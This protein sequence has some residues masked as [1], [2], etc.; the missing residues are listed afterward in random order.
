[1]KLKLCIPKS[2]LLA[3]LLHVFLSF[4]SFSQ[5]PVV[6]QPWM[7]VEGTYNG[8]RLG[9]NV[10]FAGKIDD[11]T[12]ITASD[13]NGIKMYHIKSPNDT[14]PRFFFSGYN[15]SLG[16]F[17][18]DGIQ[19]LLVNGK[20]TKIYLG[21][22]V[23]VF[24]T[25][26]FFTK[27]ME[28]NGYA[29][30]RR[31]AVG[32]INEDLFDD[33]IITDAGYPNGNNVGRVYIFFGGMQ[34][35]TIPSYI[36]NG[37]YNRSGFGWN[38]ATGDLN[39]DGIDDIIVRGYD[40]NNPVSNQR[41][42]YIKVFLGGNTID[43]TTWKYIKGIL[44]SSFGLSC[45]DVNGDGVKDL[46]WTNYSI[47]DSMNSVYIHFSQN[48]NIDTLPSLVLPNSWAQNVT[49]AGDMNGDG[50]DDILISSNGSD[51]GGNSYIFIYSGG[52][53]MD[54]HFDAAVGLGG[55]SNLG[56]FGSIV[57]IGDVNNDSY[58]DILVGAPEFQWFS[59]KGKW[60]V[61]LGDSG[62]PITTIRVEDFSPPENFV[63]FQNFP[64]PFNPTTIISW[65]SSV[66]SHTTI[67]I[68]D[69]LGSEITTLIDEEKPGGAYEVE[70]DGSKLSSGV[71]YYKLTLT[72]SQ[73][74]KQTQTKSMVLIK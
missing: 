42:P 29:F 65:Q 52:P 15:C 33:L 9:Q 74:N 5:D 23:G 6:L 12:K 7:Q 73:G 26:P 2:L 45:F 14:V 64:N 66:F 49:N 1:M 41:F 35:D 54:I 22:I 37:G 13:V 69:L 61:F 30:G 39:T 57:G 38:V 32:K 46:L 24:D 60:F 4:E 71:Y 48:N 31:V 20:P 34:M 36:L 3:A 51:Q 70:F 17:N 21:I 8:Q 59:E 63:L 50:Y 53:K 72:D 44:T 47:A 11:S 10:G 16:D 55:V 62:I 67:K 27:N 28:P 43:T 18:G 58:S 68:F 56:A 40:S 25:I 19:D